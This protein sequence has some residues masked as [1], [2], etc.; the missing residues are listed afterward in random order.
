MTHGPSRAQTARS[1]G[2]AI[3]AV[4][5]CWLCNA[6]QGGPVILVATAVPP[7]EAFRTYRYPNGVFSLRLP[8]DWSIRDVS[9]TGAIRVEFS[10]P[11]N[12]GLPL[13][14]YVVNTGQPIDTVTLLNSLSP[15]QVTLNGSSADY[16]EISRNAQG[17]GSWRL[18]GIRHTSIG[19]R[20]LNI[21]VQAD[22]TFLSALQIDLTNADATRLTLLRAVANTLRINASAQ[23][24]VN[25]NTGALAATPDVNVN[26][27]S[28]GTLTFDS[29][30]E[31]TD[32]SG[33]F[34]I[35]GQV[36]NHSGNPLEAVRITGL[37]YDAQSNVLTQAENVLDAA[38]LLDGMT[39][40]FSLRFR[41]GKLPQAV[42]YEL[43]GAARDAHY[44]LQT[45]L[46]PD[47]FLKGNEK[48]SYNAAGDLVISGDLV[49]KTTQ[50]GH[51]I[52][53]AVTVYDIQ[54]RVAG[55]QT[56]F[57][58]KPDLLPGETSHYEVTFYQLAGNAARFVTRAEGRTQ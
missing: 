53:I 40:S 57:V 13:T 7:D 48:A 43:Q 25:N 8:A 4:L 41:D 12:D 47:S 19:D 34:N 45:Y 17:D 10:P 20:Q 38:V 36:T 29:F 24:V 42:R 30:L 16:H 1:T 2:F 5:F 55:T 44:N 32:S 18:V 39:A 22:Q 6:C 28:V 51:A 54:Q 15:F 35:N 27:A 23:L 58:A 52:R 33:G 37:L 3:L 11:N 49:N 46:G 56:T 31:W 14:I 21:F 50:P 9:S 26:N